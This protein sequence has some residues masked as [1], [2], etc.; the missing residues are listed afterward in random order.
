L[1]TDGAGLT[2]EPD[3]PGPRK[4]RRYHPLVTT[5]DTGG[6]RRDPAHLTATNPQRRKVHFWRRSPAVRW[7]SVRRGERTL[8]GARATDVSRR[9]SPLRV[10]SKARHRSHIRRR[11]EARSPRRCRRPERMVRKLAQSCERSPHAIQARICWLGTTYVP[12][13][14]RFSSQLFPGGGNLRL[15]S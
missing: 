10:A 11:T 4:I 14:R 7:L 3:S 1:E 15:P 12:A 6:R 2:L 13:R 8:A 9:P 5:V